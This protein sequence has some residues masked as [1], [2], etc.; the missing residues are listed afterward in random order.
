MVEHLIGH[1]F[2]AFAPLHRLSDSDLQVLIVHGQQDAAIAVTD[3]R[4]L[5]AVARDGGLVVVKGAGHSDLDAVPTVQ[6]AL[7]RL[8]DRTGRAAPQP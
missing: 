5:A 1:R 4:A 8:L 7:R 6:A 2:A 3:A